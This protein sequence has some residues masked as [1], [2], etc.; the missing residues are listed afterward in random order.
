M[1]RRR[2]GKVRFSCL[3]WDCLPKVLLGLLVFPDC[4]AGQRVSG[5]TQQRSPPQGT[6]GSSMDCNMCQRTI[7][8]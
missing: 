5:W 1:R 6:D 8:L 3:A 4:P 7:G 2:D